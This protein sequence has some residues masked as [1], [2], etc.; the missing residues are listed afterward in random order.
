MAAAYPIVNGVV[1]FTTRSISSISVV[2][3]CS[4]YISK[5]DALACL[6]LLKILDNLV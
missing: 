2:E 4:E 1:G 6:I 5:A 3:L